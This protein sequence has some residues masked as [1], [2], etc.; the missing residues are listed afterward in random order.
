MFVDYSIPLNGILAAVQDFNQAAGRIASANLR[1][2]D[3]ADDSVYISDF[4]EDLISIQRSKTAC[5]ANLKVI[6]TQ[7]ELEHEVLDLFA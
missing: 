5:E 1:T 4:A 6:S 7:Q 2:S 3:G